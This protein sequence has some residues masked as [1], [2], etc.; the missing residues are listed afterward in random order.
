[1]AFDVPGSQ[2]I[3]DGI[4]LGWEAPWENPHTMMV[5]FAFTVVYLK[6]LNKYIHVCIMKDTC[7]VW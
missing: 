5:V 3:P 6:L 4:P 7:E 2:A 1:M